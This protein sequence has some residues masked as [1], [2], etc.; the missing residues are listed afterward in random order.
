VFTKATGLN[1]VKA[2]KRVTEGIQAVQRRFVLRPDGTA[3]LT[4]MRDSVVRRDPA[5]VDAK[6]PASTIEEI[7][8]YVWDTGAGA[9]IK[10]TPLK[11]GDHG[12]DAMRYLV[13]QKDLGRRTRID[14][15]ISW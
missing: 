14:R 1:T 9:A 7:P 6:K 12:A 15:V 11:I 3:P 5:L 2:D 8:G 13:M 4:M 10:E